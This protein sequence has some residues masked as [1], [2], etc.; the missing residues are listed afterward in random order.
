MQKVTTFEGLCLPLR[1]D[2]VDTDLIIPAQYL[3][4]V[5]AAGY[6]ENLFKRLRDNPD[7][8]FNQERY[9]Q[10]SILITQ[11]NFGCGSSRE[12]AVWAIKEAGFKAV[13]AH[14]FSDIFFNNSSKNGLLLVQL[15]DDTIK[16]LLDMAESAPLHLTIDLP[17]EKIVLANEDSISFTIEPFRKHCLVNGL[18]DLAYLQSYREDIEHY[19]RQHAV[20]EFAAT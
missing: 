19:K 3:T 2:D 10:A 14:S 12:H 1:M 8:V 7:F 15:Q 16:Q 13:I 18:D 20:L 4:S 5:S 11:N 17:Q 6:G 9:Q